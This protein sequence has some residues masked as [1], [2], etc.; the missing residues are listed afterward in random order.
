[1]KLEINELEQCEF[2]F[3]ISQFQR[4]KVERLEELRHLNIAEEAAHVSLAW[5]SFIKDT[6]VVEQQLL[7]RHIVCFL[8]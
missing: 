8:D 7:H 3:V 2:D 1:M 6:E 5:S 4:V